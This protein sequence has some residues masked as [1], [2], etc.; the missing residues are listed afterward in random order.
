MNVNYFNVS[1]MISLTS[2]LTKMK[3]IN[4]ND[5]KKGKEKGVCA[6]FSTTGNTKSHVTESN[7]I[8]IRE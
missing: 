7:V 4:E 8:I 5:I 6:R 2:P 1:I 3:K